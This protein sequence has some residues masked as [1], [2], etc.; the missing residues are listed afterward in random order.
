[1]P[2]IKKATDANG[3]VFYPINISKAVFDT[4]RNQRLNV[5]LDDIYDALQYEDIYI[6]AGATSAAV[7]VAAN[8]HDT[9]LRGRPSAVTASSGYLWVVLPASYDKP[10]TLMG[11]I[12]VPMSQDGT[13]TI[14]GNSY[15]V[16]KST[17]TYTGTFNI[18]LF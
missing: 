4:D 18:F 13:T 6:G 14:S 2:R 11:G 1:M 15:K 5:T 7:A 3:S 9:L 16:W 10:L 17:N 12:E 8:H